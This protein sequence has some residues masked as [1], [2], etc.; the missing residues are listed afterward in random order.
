MITDDCKCGHSRLRHF[1]GWN[2]T[3]PAACMAP[4][5]ECRSFVAVDLQKDTKK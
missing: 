2:V 3:K 5:C 1:V 4:E